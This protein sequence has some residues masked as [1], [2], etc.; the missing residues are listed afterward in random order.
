MKY[1][2][3]LNIKPVG[4]IKLVILSLVA[5]PVAGNIS[6]ATNS[7]Y[8]LE[9]LLRQRNN[10][11][12]NYNNKKHIPTARIAIQAEIDQV[13]IKIKNMKNQSGSVQ[14]EYVSKNSELVCLEKY[15]IAYR[16]CK[17]FVEPAASLL[18]QDRLFSECL[19]FKGFKNGTSTCN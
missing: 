14:V 16:D 19:E 6:Y 17:D 1:I 18:K 2:F 15:N 13:D 4:L 11:I 5:L 3:Q 8:D 7:N 9:R 12:N 10:L